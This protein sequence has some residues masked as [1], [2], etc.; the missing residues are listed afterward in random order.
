MQ[1]LLLSI[2]FL[3]IVALTQAQDNFNIDE[4]PNILVREL[5][6]FRLKNGLDTFEVNQVLIDAAAIDAKAFIKSG[7]AK[8]DPEKVQKNLVKAGG[9]KKGEEVAM[10]A[11]VSKGRDNYK[12]GGCC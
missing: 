8:V 7:Q 6:K 1:K 3:F 12:T 2:A 11:P 9:T 5:N 10:L 4:L